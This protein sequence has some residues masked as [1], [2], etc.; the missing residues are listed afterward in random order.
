M[1]DLI[2]SRYNIS[3]EEWKL[4]VIGGKIITSEL[5]KIL[6]LFITFSFLNLIF[7]FT[8]ISITLCTLRIKSGGLHF[9]TY[10]KCLGYT[11]FFY[12]LCIML[13]KHFRP[14]FE[15]VLFIY[16]FCLFIC[17]IIGPVRHPSRPLPSKSTIKKCRIYILFHSISCTIITTIFLH[18]RIITLI[19]IVFLL[20]THQLLF[21][22][23]LQKKRTGTN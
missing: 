16:V 17:Y 10:L 14:N 2:K 4:L 22:Y 19:P 7:E 6:I 21:A 12:T 13:H 11:F 8:I 23:A 1:I 15:D 18:I 9:K 5:S 3:D 20:H